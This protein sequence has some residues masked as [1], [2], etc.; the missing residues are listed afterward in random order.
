MAA[1]ISDMADV[2]PLADIADD[3]EIGPFCTIGPDV[4]LGRGTRLLNHVTIT[5]CTRLGQNNKV[6]PGAVIGAEPQDASYCGSPTRV[7]IGDRN[8]IRECVTINRA[9]E[10]EAGVTR[11]GSRCYLMA[12]THIAHD[13]YLGDGVVIAN[14]TLLAGHVR[15]DHHA[16]LS[17]SVGVHHYTTIGSYSFVSGLSRVLNDVPPYMLVDG[18]P[19]RPRC[20]N[21]VALK[22]HDFPH[23]YIQALTEAHRLIY[24]AKLGLD[25]AREILRSHGSLVPPVHHL[26]NF[27]QEQQE[28]RHGRARQ[29][30]RAA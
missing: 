12:C 13:C 11:I 14:G 17:G 21:I 10:K 5:G 20:L 29:R 22:R 30:R 19:A 9:T 25:H 23:E 8:V 26:L 24:R 4:V 28:G 6:Y 7:V 27:L 18:D 3:V 2:D 15:V 16:T 1:A